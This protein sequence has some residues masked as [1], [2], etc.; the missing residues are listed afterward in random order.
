MWESSNTKSFGHIA[1]EFSDGK[2]ISWW[3][4]TEKKTSENEDARLE[5]SSEKVESLK[6]ILVGSEATYYDRF[7]DELKE[8]GNPNKTLHLVELNEDNMITY[9]KRLLEGSKKWDLWKRRCSSVI[10]KALCEGSEWFKG[11]AG[12]ITT[13]NAVVG[14]V[15]AFLKGKE[16][17]KIKCSS[18]K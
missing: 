13:P 9:F 5:R 2:Y 3:P 14:L 7:E 12:E 18:C 15:E 4:V 6:K 1:L 17:K 10:Y 16:D 8:N 11:R